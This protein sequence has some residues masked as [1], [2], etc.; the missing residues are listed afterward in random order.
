MKPKD[1]L[2]TD[3]Y[4]T[5]EHAEPKDNSLLTCFVCNGS[6]VQHLA[7]NDGWNGTVGPNGGLVWV[8]TKDICR[9]TARKKGVVVRR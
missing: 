9:D 6:M 8:C 2:T 1:V 3:P 5:R 7:V 4:T